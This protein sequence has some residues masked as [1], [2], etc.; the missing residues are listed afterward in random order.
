MVSVFRECSSLR[1]SVA[2]A[3]A[4]SSSLISPCRSATV[5]LF[6]AMDAANSSI[7]ACSCS[8]WEVRSSLFTLLSWSSLLHQ[9]W[10]WA[11]SPASA[12]SRSIKSLIMVFT[13]AMG[14]PCSVEE[15]CAA[16]S[17]KASDFNELARCWTNSSN[18][19][20]LLGVALRRET[21]D[22]PCTRVGRCFFADP[23]TESELRISVAFW[24]ALISSARVAVLW[25]KSSVSWAHSALSSAKV[26]LSSSRLAVVASRSA[27]ASAAALFALPR[28]TAL[29]PRWVLSYS[30]WSVRSIMS[31]S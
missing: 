12:S 11:S 13:L 22:T 18:F 26:F 9:A 20:L 7:A 6:C 15:S 27:V 24:R 16:S 8:D 31:S 1:T 29:L 28:A 25:L 10:C 30:T 5:C 4:A 14:S 2:L 19:A 3:M 21:R 17:E 23:A